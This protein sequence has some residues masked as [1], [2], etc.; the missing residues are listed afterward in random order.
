MLLASSQVLPARFTRDALEPNCCG[1]ATLRVQQHQFSFSQPS[2]FLLLP[3]VEYSFY[4]WEHA[5]FDGATYV[6]L[7]IAALQVNFR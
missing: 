1:C 5:D 4:L 6:E 3:A 2:V 7:V